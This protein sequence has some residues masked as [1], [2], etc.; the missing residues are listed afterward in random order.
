MPR[1]H[2]RDFR[3]SRVTDALPMLTALRQTEILTAAEPSAAHIAHVPLALGYRCRRPRLA[4]CIHRSPLSDPVGPTL[5]CAAGHDQRRDHQPTPAAVLARLATL[6]RL[7]RRAGAD[8]ARCRHVDT[9][10]VTGQALA[11]RF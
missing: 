1:E 6:R 2:R 4:Y 10:A 11:G 9:R 8:L 7:L 3:G 5:T